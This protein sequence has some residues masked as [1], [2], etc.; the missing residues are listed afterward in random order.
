MDP[1]IERGDSLAG[2]AIFVAAN[3]DRVHQPA[4]CAR[5]GGRSALDGAAGDRW[6]GP[7]LR[8][9]TLDDPGFALTAVAEPV[10]EPAGASLPELDPLRDYAVATPEVGPRDRVVA[11]LRRQSPELRRELL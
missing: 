7:G 4:L 2:A 6:P 1:Q 9:Q 5:L 11:E 10:V 3:G 8:R